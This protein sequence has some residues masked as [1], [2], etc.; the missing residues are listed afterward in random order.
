MPRLNLEP[1]HP[2]SPS[3]IFDPPLTPSTPGALSESVLAAREIHAQVRDIAI[4]R[5]SS[6]IPK[7]STT[8]FKERTRRRSDAKLVVGERERQLEL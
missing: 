8:Q 2:A 4:T 7:S 1:C 5:S 6:Q 3:P